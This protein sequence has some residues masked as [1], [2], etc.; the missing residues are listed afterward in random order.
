M[1]QGQVIVFTRVAQ[2][3]LPREYHGRA[4][5]LYPNGVTRAV[6]LEFALQLG[7]CSPRG[8]QPSEC[9]A[10]LLL[11]TVKNKNKHKVYVKRTPKV[12]G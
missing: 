8:S 7:K 12:V 5:L 3:S 1:W 9:R 11:K 10:A 6:C 2:R 4:L